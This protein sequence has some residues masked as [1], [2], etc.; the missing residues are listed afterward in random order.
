MSQDG[1]P[2][3]SAALPF[4]SA[5]PSPSHHELWGEDGLLGR[6][7]GLE[8]RSGDQ[9]RAH[10]GRQRRGISGV[11]HSLLSGRSF[12]CCKVG[13][14]S[15]PTAQARQGE[16]PGA[17]RFPTY[18]FSQPVLHTP[19]E[20]T[21]VS[22]WA[23]APRRAGAIPWLVQAALPGSVLPAA[24]RV[25]RGESLAVSGTQSSPGS[26]RS[27]CSVAWLLYRAAHE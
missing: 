24:G 10:L 15:V 1:R 13:A 8:L 21:H 17:P 14:P 4:S 27:A 7:P 2:R 23:I 25:L 19:V 11:G 3:G 22:L 16:E 9:L 20:D 6:V 18:S 12:C 26:N 5:G